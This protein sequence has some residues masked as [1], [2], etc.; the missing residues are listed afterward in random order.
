MNPIVI[1][2]VKNI[3]KRGKEYKQLMYQLRNQ[4]DLI[5]KYYLT[6]GKKSILNSEIGR[7][8]RLY[9]RSSKRRGW[10]RNR[11]SISFRRNK[12]KINSR[13]TGT[14][15][16]NK[17]ILLNK[18]RH[19]KL[20]N[21]Y[22]ALWKKKRIFFHKSL[23]KI[24][25]QVTSLTFENNSTTKKESFLL[26]IILNI[27]NQ[28]EALYFITLI[29]KGLLNRRSNNEGFKRHLE[30]NHY[31]WIKKTLSNFS[32]EYFA[33]LR[34]FPFK[35]SLNKNLKTILSHT[36]KRWVIRYYSIYNKKHLFKFNKKKLL[37]KKAIKKLKIYRRF[38]LT[39]TNFKHFKISNFRKRLRKIRRIYI[40][41]R[42]KELPKIVRTRS[43]VTFFERSTH[44]KRDVFFNSFWFTKITNK[45]IKRGRKHFAENIISRVF[46]AL[47]QKTKNETYFAFWKLLLKIKPIA[48]TVPKRV[49]KRYHNIPIPIKFQRGFR[50]GL[51]WLLNA[52]KLRENDKSLELRIYNEISAILANQRTYTIKQRDT[53][54]KVIEEN[55]TYAHYRWV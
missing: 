47:K 26:K 54:Y 40:R 43:L 35:K 50:L 7:Y 33:K 32:K 21:I 46:L 30:R 45:F 8:R 49:G 52:I 9:K 11:F 1:K 23:R 27:F 39:Y 14:T 37:Q 22:W 16:K 10:V 55:S 12:H 29:Y 42:K 41:E 38:R 3:R 51:T 34:G 18:P 13:K 53:L 28:M 24:H 36:T 44:W 19:K 25:K 31:G 15:R 6:H 5:T 20:L 17:I 2:L 48:T 4:G